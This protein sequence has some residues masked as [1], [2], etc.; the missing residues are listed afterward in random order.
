MTFRNS[1]RERFRLLETFKAIFDQGH[2]S[3]ASESLGITQSAAS[4]HLGK[5]RDWFDDELF[6]RTAQGMQPTAKALSIVERVERI[7]SEMD[8]LTA[9]SHFDPAT[10]QGNFVIATTDEVRQQL[11]PNLLPIIQESAPKLRI[12]LIPLESDYSLQKLETGI[13]NLTISVIWHAPE[14]LMLKR[15]FGDRFVCL[16]SKCHPLAKGKLTLENYANASHLMVAPLGMQHGYI[17][18]QLL[19]KGYKRFV[20]L[21]VPDFSQITDG[22]LGNNNIVTLPHR[23][24]QNVSK[25][26]PLDIK[27]LPFEV[28]PIDYFA[29][30]HRR[31]QHDD[32]RIWMLNLVANILTN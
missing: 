22:L 25:S 27:I 21:S 28:P 7:L 12:T 20:R 3:Q 6:V 11:L 26:A 29:F 10:V 18:D 2:V 1:Y 32:L 23:V 14:Q 15:L 31:F 5:L 4:K 16:M 13:V 24:A 17:D 30:W 19:Q 8:A 9:E